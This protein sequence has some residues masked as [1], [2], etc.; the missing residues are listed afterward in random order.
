MKFILIWGA[1]LVAAYVLQTA[2]LPL[3]N[4]NGIGMDLLLLVVVSFSL[5]K[6]QRFGILLG[7]MAGLLQD[8]ASGTFFGMNTLSKMMIGYIFGLAS[9]QVFK[10]KF[11]LPVIGAA[12]AT[13]INYL[14]LALLMLLLGYRF[15][16][17]YNLE[18]VLLPMLLYNVVA[19]FPVHLVVCWLCQKMK[20]K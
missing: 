16:P 19:A 10:E 18:N 3:L 1:V 15:N 20:E 6:G 17:L 8:L 5:L 4:F 11:F 12:M 9:Q 7:F 13:G 14:V 2:F